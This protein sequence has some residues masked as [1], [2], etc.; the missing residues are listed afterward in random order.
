MSR[1][2]D[3]NGFE[4]KSTCSSTLTPNRSCEVRQYFVVVASQNVMSQCINYIIIV[5]VRIVGDVLQW[6]VGMMRL[7]SSFLERK[8]KKICYLLSFESL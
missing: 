8:N 2:K 6:M 7:V 1:G 5:Y 4:G 3:I